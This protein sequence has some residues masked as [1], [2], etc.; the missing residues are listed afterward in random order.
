[1]RVIRPPRGSGYIPSDHAGV[2][3]VVQERGEA[4]RAGGSPPS[5]ELKIA[6]GP[7]FPFGVTNGQPDSLENEVTLPGERRTLCFSEVVRTIEDALW[8]GAP[9]PG[10]TLPFLKMDHAKEATL[11]AAVNALSIGE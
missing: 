10:G 7:P 2:D 9:P 3:A 5:E 8:Y 4:G 11:A 6:P 1:M